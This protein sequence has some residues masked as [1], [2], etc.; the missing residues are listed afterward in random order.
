M[1][2]EQTADAALAAA[3]RALIHQA[4]TVGAAFTIAWSPPGA[5]HERTTDRPT[6]TRRGY[7]A[8][9]ERL[10]RRARRLQRFCSDCGATEDLTVDH[11]PEAWARQARGLSIRLCDVQILC[12]SCNS[13]KGAAR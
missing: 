6:H 8:A 13:R 10:S 5:E 7:N 9:W 12:R 2:P 4:V 3:V 11:S 1:T